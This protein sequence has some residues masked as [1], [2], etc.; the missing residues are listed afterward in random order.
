MKLTPKQLARD[1]AQGKIAPVY[2]FFGDDD[3]RMNEAIRFLRG[4][5]LPAAAQMTNNTRIDLNS[6]KFTDVRDELMSL[7]FFGERSLLTIV[8][9]QKLSPKQLTETLS[10]LKTPVE[11]RLVI[12]YTRAAKKPDRRSSLPK[13]LE[14]VATIVEFPL[15]TI[16]D[17]QDKVMRAMRDAKIEIDPLAA[18]ELAGMTGC[19]AGKLTCEI[20][21]LIAYASEERKITVETVRSVA[22]ETVSRT[23]YQLVDAVVDA[24]STGAG[25]PALEAL[26]PVLEGGDTPTGVLYWLGAGFLDMYLVKDG[27]KLPPYKERFRGKIER[28][29]SRLSLQQI[30]SALALITSSEAALKGGISDRPTEGKPALYELILALCS[31]SATKPDTARRQLSSHY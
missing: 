26:A 25:A 9:P 1:I 30:E 14:P 29:V 5:F 21:K 12:F 20:E 6:Q 24:L 17:A 19:D 10:L 27:R 11:S 18:R 2:Y 31:L 8:N 15:L 16:A 3:H 23:V 28:Q 13:K 4:K 7:P 22:S